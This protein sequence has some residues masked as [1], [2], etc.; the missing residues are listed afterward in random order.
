M[1]GLRRGDRSCIRSAVEVFALPRPKNWQLLQVA[2]KAM[3]RSDVIGN[4]KRHLI[5]TDQ[6]MAGACASNSKEKLCSIPSMVMEKNQPKI[7]RSLTQH[8]GL[9]PRQGILGK[10]PIYRTAG[11]R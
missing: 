8:T 1:Q 7:G 5:Y 9:P 3:G 4:G 11:K 2:L 10:K 6:P